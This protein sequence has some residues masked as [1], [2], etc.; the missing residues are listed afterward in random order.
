MH[1]AV[2]CSIIPTLLASFPS[3]SH[4]LLSYLCFLRSPPTSTICTQILIS[5]CA[6]EATQSKT[7]CMCCPFLPILTSWLGF[8]TFSMKEQFY[9]KVFIW[10]QGAACL[11]STNFQID[12]KSNHSCAF[13]IS[14]IQMLLT[15]LLFLYPQPIMPH[16]SV[17]NTIAP[18]ISW[19]LSG[20]VDVVT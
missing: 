11:L 1:T 2:C 10:P 3:L 9:S 7:T 19:S 15:H 8:P 13:L 14:C 16:T 17:T 5:G 4:F 12:P 20:C 6:S 18:Q